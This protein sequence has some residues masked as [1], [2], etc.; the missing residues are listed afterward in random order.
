MKYMGW[1]PVDLY[2]AS[3]LQV[4]MVL[5]LVREEYE[6]SVGSGEQDVDA[7]LIR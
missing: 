1:S 6:T 7:D 2:Y 5:E 4:D 3:Q